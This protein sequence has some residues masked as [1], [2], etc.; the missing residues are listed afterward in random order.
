MLTMSLVIVSLVEDREWDWKCEKGQL[1]VRLILVRALEINQ[2]HGFKQQMK[3]EK[4]KNANQ[5]E[6]EE[7]ENEWEEKS[8]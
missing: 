2:L 7:E 6:E 1:S 8:W 4:E 5:K 3:R